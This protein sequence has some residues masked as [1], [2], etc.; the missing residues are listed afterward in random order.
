LIGAL[1]AETAETWQ[2]RL[3][4]DMQDFHEW[5]SDRSKNSGSN[6]L[7]SAAS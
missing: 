6:A 4:L 2:E 1:L 3:Y 5:Q 7:L